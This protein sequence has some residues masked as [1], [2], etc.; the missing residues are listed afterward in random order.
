MG[1]YQQFIEWVIY[2]GGLYV[3]ILIIFAETGLFAGFFL[4]GDSLLFTTGI[5][6]N[7]VA[8]NFFHVHYDA[9]M[10]FN[11]HYALIL[12][13]LVVASFAG[14]VAGYWFGY[15]T[16]PVM[17]KW[18]DGLLFKRRYL[19]R[20]REFYHHYGN[21]TI[22]FAKFLPIIRTFAPLVAG[23]VQMPK[24]NFSLYNIAGSICWVT[25]MILGGHFL[26]S[27]IDK[28]YGFSLKD[29]LGMITIIIVLIT[30]LPI[31]YK[32]IFGK[33]KETLKL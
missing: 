15:K 2:H 17:F 11:F 10:F 7:E 23:I 21:G 16:G 24:K 4:P 5:Y 20:A 31:L 29:H 12:L 18:K 28:K 30:T 33:K 9:S 32:F 27:W 22:F 1:F 26:Q 14:N 3:V 25:L 13:F 19:S 6:I 8:S